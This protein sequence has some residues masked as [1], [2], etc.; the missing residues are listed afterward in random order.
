M[1]KYVPVAEE[2]HQDLG[3]IWNITKIGNTIYGTAQGSIIEY[4]G[5]NLTRHNLPNTNRLTS[6]TDQQAL[7]I[8]QNEIG[9]HILKPGEEMVTITG[10]KADVARVHSEFISAQGTHIFATF[11]NG[12]LELKDD[13]LVPWNHELQ[14]LLNGTNCY[15]SLQLDDGRILIATHQSGV[16]LISPDGESLGQ[17]TEEDGLLSNFVINMFQDMDGS[18]WIAHEIGLSLLDLLSPYTIL[19]ERNGLATNIVY[20]LEQQ[21]NRL[22]AGTANGCMEFEPPTENNLNGSWKLL[23]EENSGIWHI[24]KTS[25]G[26]LI[27]ENDGFGLLTEN[28]LKTVLSLGHEGIYATTIT[29]NDQEY[30][31]ATQRR[32]L[33]ICQWQGQELLVRKSIDAPGPL[34]TIV[35]FEDEVYLGSVANGVL[36]VSQEAFFSDEPVLLDSF[37]DSLT[38]AQS[39]GYFIKL[40]RGVVL[41]TNSGL[42]YRANNSDDW[43]R[44]PGSPKTYGANPYAVNFYQSS[45]SKL[46]ISYLEDKGYQFAQVNWSEDSLRP[47]VSRIPVEGLKELNEIHSLLVDEDTSVAWFGGSGGIVRERSVGS[48]PDYSERAPI[49][50][51][52][53]IAGQSTGTRNEFKF[54]VK[55][56]TFN[57]ALPYYGAKEV[58]YRTR[59]AGQSDD[60]SQATTNTFKEFTNLAEGEYA[61]QVQALLDG[62]PLPSIA[63]HSFRILPP[64]YRTWGA[65]ILYLLGAIALAY[66]LV[67][68]R[69]RSLQRA[70][71]MLEEAVRNRTVEL[72]KT[73][74]RLA[75]ANTAK[76]RFLANVSH[77]IRNPMNGIVGLA[78][79]LLE[80]GRPAEKRRLTHLL[81][82]SEHLKVLLDGLLDFAAIENGQVRLQKTTFSL[83]TLLDEL[84]S[85]H[86]RLALDKGIELIVEKRFESCPELYGDVGKLRQILYNLTSNAIKFTGEGSVTVR[87][88]TQH[89]KSHNK[90]ELYFEIED[91]GNG[92]RPEDQKR[93]FEQFNRGANTNSQIK[94][95]GLGLS[96]AD[97]LAKLLDGA[98]ELDTQ[99]DNGARFTLRLQLPFADQ[100]TSPENGD[101]SSCAESLKGLQAL[102]IEDES[103]NQIV[104]EGLLKRESV[105]VTLA[106]SAEEGI[107][108]FVKHNWDFVLVDINLPGASGIEFAR[109]VRDAAEKAETPLIA[110]S[111]YVADFDREEMIKAGITGFVPKPFTPEE[112]TN[113]IQAKTQSA[114]PS[115]TKA[116]K[117]KVS[118][119]KYI[120]GDDANRLKDLQKELHESLQSYCE[121]LT[122]AMQSN[123]LESARL[124]LHDMAPL[125]RLTQDDHLI[126][127]TETL[128]NLVHEGDFKGFEQVFAEFVSE[129]GKLAPEE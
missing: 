37:L 77:E 99:Y 95:I 92:I 94:G 111:A 89:D 119:M 121:K 66:L 8:S 26:P 51:D 39:W 21:D 124:L 63:S 49:I 10:G 59:M 116:K 40:A 62:V 29:H 71:V 33:H 86:Q 58:S 76:N 69:T 36:R 85:L 123:D 55:L 42:H 30:I 7:Y 81:S 28:Q 50:T 5:K 125:I 34:W 113:A 19:N 2:I 9:L 105:K 117:D 75:Q 112:L 23:G 74:V 73:N 68:F 57:F 32:Q 11:R 16:L 24:A 60:W 45:D 108:E 114:L 46:W 107:K 38:N 120:A 25:R 41:L 100:S 70:N 93:I 96:I 15:K 127:L 31:L 47:L 126:H 65:F 18:I 101:D 3:E 4:D 54:P 44:V 53:E 80:D 61:F 91:T 109:M 78:H 104:V 115:L 48:K 52:S 110:M 129:C 79:L 56:A 35:N 98:L 106:S 12:L 87:A 84:E 14:E 103:Y 72:E 122:K 43:Q 83:E 27:A 64:W 128:H 88:F 67:Y 118:L 90:T 17:I 1:S 6:A 13:A 82:T 97:R 102:V 20:S 22:L